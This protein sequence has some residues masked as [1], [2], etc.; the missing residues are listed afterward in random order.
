MYRGD[1][2]TN[3]KRAVCSPQGKEIVEEREDER[4]EKCRKVFPIYGPVVEN[5][6]DMRTAGVRF[7]G[8][9]C[10]FSGCFTRG[11]RAHHAGGPSS[12]HGHIIIFW[13]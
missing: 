13:G 6:L 3:M 9:K 12:N 5:S 10:F 4:L 11:W 8:V 1:N 7:P 2:Y